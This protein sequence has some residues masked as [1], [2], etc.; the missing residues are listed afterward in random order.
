MPRVLLRIVFAVLVCSAAASPAAAQEQPAAATSADVAKL[1]GQ[2]DSDDY[3][4]R[5]QA[6]R[7]LAEA[8]P[9]AVP[10]LKKAAAGDSL[11]ASIRAIQVLSE[12]Y[13][14][15]D[16][17]TVDA[18]EDVLDELSAS[19]ATSVADRAAAAL[20]AHNEIR[21]RR[22][23]ARL[24]D[25]G[26]Q[27][28]FATTDQILID[29]EQP[30]QKRVAHV[31]I[32]HDWRGEDD[33]LKY[34]HRLQSWASVPTVYVVKDA[35]VTDE[36][37]NQLV[38]TM[39]QVK[40]ERRGKA[41]LGVQSSVLAEECIV[42]GITPG[43]AADRAGLQEGDIIRSFGGEAVGDFRALVDLIANKEPGDRVE[44]GYLRGGQ[45]MTTEVQ[46]DVWKL[47]KSA[48]PAQQKKP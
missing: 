25:L 16:P 44:V 35:P 4:T 18:A 19:E 2:L 28:Q 10:A 30:K 11:E 45:M 7:K 26:G 29:E 42:G 38:A 15:E 37:L 22:A 34:L 9:E 3:V 5:Q 46:L 48:E 36:G 14:T 40:I 8:G 12:I 27:V 6:T 24:E 21:D 20:A 23:L 39:P 47:Q 13:A 17:E 33:G 32:G 31:L 1:V 43:S 41:M